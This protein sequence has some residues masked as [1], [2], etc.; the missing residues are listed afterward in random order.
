MGARARRACSGPAKLCCCIVLGPPGGSN[1]SPYPLRFRAFP[2][3]APASPSL[4][5]SS[6]VVLVGLPARAT[7]P[8]KDGL[9]RLDFCV[10]WPA[11]T[12][13][14]PSPDMGP[15]SSVQI[16][17]HWCCE[18]TVAFSWRYLLEAFLAG[19]GNEPDL[20]AGS[21]H[22]PSV[23]IEV[24][25]QGAPR[26]SCFPRRMQRCSA[27]GEDGCLPVLWKS[28]CRR[29]PPCNFYQYSQPGPSTACTRPCSTSTR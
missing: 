14:G 10:E 15:R 1:R 24:N 22:A 29:S 5:V 28:I 18:E 11:H 16:S 7:P 4:S 13:L 26:G 20:P 27:D 6:D 17:V 23:V 2:K 9:E 25:S 8:R 19:P 12:L 21:L 3:S